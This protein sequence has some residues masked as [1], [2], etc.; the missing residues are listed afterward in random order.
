MHQLTPRI[1]YCHSFDL[2]KNMRQEYLEANPVEFLNVKELQETSTESIYLQLY[3]KISQT[4]NVFNKAALESTD[5]DHKVLRI[6][7][8]SM[9]SPF[10]SDN[11][12]SSCNLLTFMHALKGL[13]RASLAVCMISFPS[14]LHL[15]NITK[16]LQHLADIDVSLNSFKGDDRAEQF[17]DY[18]GLFFI[19][20]L[21]RINT[22]ISYLPETLVYGFTRKR[23]KLYIE[24][25]NLPPETSRSTNNTKQTH[26]E[27]M[28]CV[29]GKQANPLDF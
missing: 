7:I 25:L 1:K 18:T 19:R 22:M 15:A 14:H 26:T 8:D 4:V 10:W 21:A 12:T 20:K 13:L 2:S 3:N 24:M 5:V 29:P 27:G 11:L 23:R 6:V 16:K 28:M 17:S 9:A